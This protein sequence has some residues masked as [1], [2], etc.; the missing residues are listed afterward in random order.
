M[1]LETSITAMRS[2]PYPVA[3]SV[4]V[5]VCGLTRASTVRRA[6]SAAKA[7]SPVFMGRQLLHQHGGVLGEWREQVDLAQ[8]R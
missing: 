3:S 8:E 6:V 5:A 7:I 4:G 2:T 1:L